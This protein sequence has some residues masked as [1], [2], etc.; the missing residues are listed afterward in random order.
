LALSQVQH[1]TGT[2]NTSGN[3]VVVTVA[4]T[5]SANLIIVGCLGT[6]SDTITGVADSAGS[7]YVQAASARA[8]SAGGRFTD[9]WY[10]KSSLSGATTVT[11]TYGTTGT[12]RREAYVHEVSGADTS[13]PFDAKGTSTDTGGASP[14]SGAAVTT[15]AANTYILAIIRT[16]GSTTGVAGGG[17]TADDFSLAGAAEHDIVSSQGT[18]TPTFA[19]S[20][21]TTDDAYS[22]V[23]FKQFSAAAFQPDED[24][25]QAPVPQAFD[26]MVTIWQ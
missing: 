18:Y 3:T 2:I 6:A 26:P 23:S 1:K 12:N 17:F 5:G 21:S 16:S 14:L 7:T 25:W 15:V 13:S 19:T 24:N 11:V 4:A 9:V 8:L 20:A 10:C 22:T